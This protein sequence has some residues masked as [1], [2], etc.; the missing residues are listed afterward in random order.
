M[1][2]HPHE[3]CV[4]V[5]KFGLSKKIISM[6]ACHSRLFLGMP[7]PMRM[8]YPEEFMVEM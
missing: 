7:L 6:Q 3:M 8:S 5:C 2:R 4:S 1:E